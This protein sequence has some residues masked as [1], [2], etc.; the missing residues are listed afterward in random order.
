MLCLRRYTR[1]E[2]A[3][4]FPG[5]ASPI[6]HWNELETGYEAF[7][8][9]DAVDRSRRDRV[10]VVQAAGRQLTLGHHGGGQPHHRQFAIRM[11]SD[12]VRWPGREAEEKY[13]MEPGKYCSLIR[14]P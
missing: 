1:F 10:G 3:P 6:L 2:C 4:K 13:C 8:H 7:V 5:L 14:H 12:V 9:N 11:K